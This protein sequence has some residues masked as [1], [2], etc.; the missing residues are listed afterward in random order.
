M[1][2]ISVSCACFLNLFLGAEND[3]IC[4]QS[5]AFNVSHYKDG[6]MESV[7]LVERKSSI[8]FDMY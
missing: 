3:I 5:T 8:A 6:D 1:E 4:P 2:S 7:K